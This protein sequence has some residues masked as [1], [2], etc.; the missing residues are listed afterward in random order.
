MPKIKKRNLLLNSEQVPTKKVDI[1][2]SY[3]ANFCLLID[4]A[5]STGDK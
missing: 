3:A 4:S 1:E 2:L 5:N